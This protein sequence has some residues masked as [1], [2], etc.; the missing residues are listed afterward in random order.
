MRC[1][2]TVGIPSFNRPNE[3]LRA[4]RS[5]PVDPRIQVI[6]SDDAS[7]MQSDVTN[8]VSSFDEGLSIEYYPQKINLG[9]DM[10][11]SFLASKANSEFIMYLSDDDVCLGDQIVRLLDLLPNSTKDLVITSFHGF[12]GELRRSL[13]H[14]FEQSHMSDRVL[15]SLIFETILFSGLI[16]RVKDYLYN[17]VSGYK[18]SIYIQ[19]YFVVAAA[20]SSG[21][22]Y[23]NIPIVAIC[24]D[25]ENGFG[26]DS[27][28]KELSN[29][30]HIL[31]D[32]KY[33]ER[34]FLVIKKVSSK[35]SK[36]I[37]RYY[38]LLYTLRMVNRLIVS[39]VIGRDEFKLVSSAALKSPASYMLLLYPISLLIGILPAVAIKYAHGLRDVYL[40][41]ESVRSKF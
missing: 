31:S 36:G 41:Y 6:I 1:I 27:G 24:G 29:R 40:K 22:Q 14:D 18:N 17:D 11:L 19:S 25:G 20:I 8:V 26:F 30:D 23:I 9:Y 13:R 32:F 16:F 4:L 33:H 34:H 21:Y 28:D 3:L 5:I 38:K 37:L 15:A 12:D 10:N 7:P 2:L 39:R 35:Y